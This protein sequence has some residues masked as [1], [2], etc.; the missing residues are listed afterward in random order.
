MR[1]RLKD[2]EPFEGRVVAP[3]PGVAICRA[4]CRVGLQVNGSEGFEERPFEEGD[5]VGLLVVVRDVLLWVAAAVTD[6][7]EPSLDHDAHPVVLPGI[8]PGPSAVTARDVHGRGVSED[9]PTPGIAMIRAIEVPG[10]AASS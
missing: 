2:E 1:N 9:P 5:V 7:I 4:E 3:S 6:P 8:R 10:P